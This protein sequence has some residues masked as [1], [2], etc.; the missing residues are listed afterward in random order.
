MAQALSEQNAAYCD[1]QLGIAHDSTSVPQ[2]LFAASRRDRL[3][4]PLPSA[5]NLTRQI[6]QRLPV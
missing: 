3:I 5:D 2:K 1:A 4:S 6:D